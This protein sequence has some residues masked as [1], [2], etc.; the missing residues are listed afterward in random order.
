MAFGFACLGEVTC[1]YLM[2]SASSFGI[3][4][5]SS[6]GKNWGKKGRKTKLST[7]PK[8]GGAKFASSTIHNKAQTVYIRRKVEFRLLVAVR[9]SVAPLLVVLEESFDCPLGEK[10]NNGEAA[11]AEGRDVFACIGAGSRRSEEDAFG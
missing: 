6:F 1:L 3:I 9:K 10:E 11:E 5:M 8:K 7:A 4:S 2:V